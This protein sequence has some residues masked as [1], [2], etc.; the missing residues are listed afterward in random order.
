MR[1]AAPSRL[2]LYSAWRASRGSFPRIRTL[3]KELAPAVPPILRDLARIRCCNVFVTM[4][5]DDLLTQARDEEGFPA[6]PRTVSLAHRLARTLSRSRAVSL[7]Y[8][9][10]NTTDLPPDACRSDAPAVFHF[11]GRLSA[12]PD[13]VITDEDTL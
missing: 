13:Y 5:F 12:S 8:S 6:A 2:P 9:P 3:R 11:R 1:C 7:T 10:N 4:T